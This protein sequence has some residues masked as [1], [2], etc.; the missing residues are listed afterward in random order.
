MAEVYDIRTRRNNL[1]FY[2]VF[3]G[4]TNVLTLDLGRMVIYLT[5][6]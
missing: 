5:E 6:C 4:F 2:N 1:T 3:T